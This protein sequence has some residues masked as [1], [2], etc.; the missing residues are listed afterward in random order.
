MKIR[1]YDL[2]QIKNLIESSGMRK[3]DIAE[4][5]G[6]KPYALSFRIY[7]R[8]SWKY[9]EIVMLSELLGFH[10]EDIIKVSRRQSAVEK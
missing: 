10:L 2:D 8:C 4:N 9:E 1:C 5:L 3:A 6:L 7:G